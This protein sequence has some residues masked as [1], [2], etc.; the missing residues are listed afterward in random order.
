M[1][2]LRARKSVIFP[3]NRRRFAGVERKNANFT[4]CGLEF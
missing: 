3:E 4:V 2:H 1:Q